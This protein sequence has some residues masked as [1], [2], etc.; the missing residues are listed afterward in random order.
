L[1]RNNY[2]IFAQNLEQLLLWEE[3]IAK[4]KEIQKDEKGKKSQ[5][6]RSNNVSFWSSIMEIE[7]NINLRYFNINLL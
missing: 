7:Y 5:L 4:K 2:G 6:F 1:L 3:K